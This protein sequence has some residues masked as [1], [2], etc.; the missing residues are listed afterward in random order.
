[1][2]KSPGILPASEDTG[3]DGWT[4]NSLGPVGNAGS[5]QQRMVGQGGSVGGTGVGAMVDRPLGHPHPIPM[6]TGLSPGTTS[7]FSFLLMCTMGGSSDNSS[8]PDTH[9]KDLD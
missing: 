2:L 6:Y 4:R 1:M 8:N 7:H 3:M 5:Y 9:V